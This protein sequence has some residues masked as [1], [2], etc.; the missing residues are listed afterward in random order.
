MRAA[1]GHVRR[2][3]ALGGGERRGRRIGDEVKDLR[4]ADALAGVLDPEEV[5]AIEAGRICTASV[6]GE[7]R[8]TGTETLPRK[9]CVA[10]EK[11]WPASVT[12]AVARPPPGANDARAICGTTL[13][14]CAD[15]ARR[16]LSSTQRK[17]DPAAA[18][19]IDTQSWLGRLRRAIGH[20][21]FP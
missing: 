16:P 8:T 13:N 4:R 12:M 18:R 10:S 21:W 7:R 20:D 19:G 17:S 6:V 3:G 2:R 11:F 1:D 9:T 14:C 5:G 15:C